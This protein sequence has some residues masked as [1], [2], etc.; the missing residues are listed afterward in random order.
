M[1]Y[2]TN[3]NFGPARVMPQGSEREGYI[4]RGQR[5]AGCRNAYFDKFFLLLFYFFFFFEYVVP[6]LMMLF[7]I[8]LK[9]AP[10][11][12]HP[13]NAIIIIVTRDAPTNTRTLH[14]G[15][16]YRLPVY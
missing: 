6:I 16:L 1:R 12:G 7:I 14:C 11:V 8:E 3:F 4:G 9:L 2:P 10:V 13:I 15:T 5:E